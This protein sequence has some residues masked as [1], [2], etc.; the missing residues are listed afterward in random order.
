MHITGICDVLF[1]YNKIAACAANH[2]FGK[3]LVC[4]GENKEKENGYIIHIPI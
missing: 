1:L 4:V 2:V 3:R